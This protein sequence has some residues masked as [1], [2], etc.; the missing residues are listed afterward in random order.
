[1]KTYEKPARGKKLFDLGKAG[2]CAG[3]ELGIH[4][5]RI[6]RAIV[7]VEDINDEESPVTGD[8]RAAFVVPA[9]A[10]VIAK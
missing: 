2:Y 9:G 3:L 8:R 7:I 5:E 6:D 4:V 10:A 1:V